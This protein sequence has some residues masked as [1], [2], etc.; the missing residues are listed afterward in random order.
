MLTITIQGEELWD[1]EAEIFRYSD[2]T[3]LELEHSLVAL[4]KWEGKFHK[5]FLTSDEKTEE[6]MAGYI[7]AMVVTPGVDES[8]LNLLTEEHIKAIDAY[9]ND[10]MTGTTFSNLAEERSRNP[11]RIS[12]ELIFL[13]MNQYQIDKDCET[14]HLNRLFTLIRVHYAKSQKP[15]RVPQHVQAKTMAEI[16]EERRRKY[17][18]NG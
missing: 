2:S 13:W 15:K 4:S 9:I 1:D 6:E 3:V 7:M 10:P 14:W 16:N 18:S 8:V 5:L 17:N 11:E 12:S